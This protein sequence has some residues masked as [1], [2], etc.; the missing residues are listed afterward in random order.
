MQLPGI[1]LAVCLLCLAGCDQS[2]QGSFPVAEFTTWRL[3]ADGT[4]IPA[5]RA[6]SVDGNDTVYALDDAG[7]VLIYSPQGDVLRTWHMPDYEAGRPEGIVKLLDG[8]I[9]VADTHYHRVV[10]FHDDGTVESMFGVQ[11]TEA[12]QF[13]YP[14]SI[15]QDP[16]GFIY[17]GEYGD[18]QRIQKF[19]PDGSFVVQF[20]EHGTGP[21]QFQRPS[22]LVWSDACI[23]AVDAFN[24]RIQVFRDTGQFVRIFEWPENAAAPEFPY[25]IHRTADGRLFVIENKGGCLTVL[26]SDGDFV[27][28]YGQPGRGDGGFFNPWSLTVLSDGRI[29]VADTGNHR[30]VELTP[31][32]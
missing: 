16:N 2:D 8:R 25:D 20:G 18:R 5:P 4:R 21:G 15:T 7:R 14:N 10:F 11:G 26:T 28:R 6:L 31:Q 27:G 24:N 32:R 29:L 1:L 3:P 13:V 19:R 30:I 22:G 23:Y 9:A 17:V 12:G